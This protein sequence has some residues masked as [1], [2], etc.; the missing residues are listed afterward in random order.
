MAR[1]SAIDPTRIAALRRAMKPAAFVAVVAA[2]DDAIVARASAARDAVAARDRAAAAKLVHTLLGLCRNF[3]AKRLAEAVARF[4]DALAGE[5]WP[6]AG[7]ADELVEVARQ[8]RRA[9][10]EFVTRS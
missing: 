3:G 4:D 9:L 1:E 8:T 2:F 5:G 10:G 7:Q 6:A